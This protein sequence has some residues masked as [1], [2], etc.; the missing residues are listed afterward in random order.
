[1]TKPTCAVNV[2]FNIIP[3]HCAQFRQAVLQQAQNSVEKEPWCHQFDVCTIPDRPN[4]FL[5]YETYD[6][7]AAFV[8]HR[9][10]PHFAD[11]NQTVAPWVESKEVGIWDIL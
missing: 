8:K 9:E 6:D 7:R 5:L 11:F 10:T 3:E 2:V 1:M 4:S